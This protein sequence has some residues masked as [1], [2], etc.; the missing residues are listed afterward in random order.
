LSS[1]SA[2][3]DCHALCGPIGKREYHSTKIDQEETKGAKKIEDQRDAI[4]IERLLLTGDP[5]DRLVIE[6]CRPPGRVNPT[7]AGKYNLV[8]IGANERHLETMKARGS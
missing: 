8:A 1:T 5:H 6:N 3:K 4:A 7:P 2:P